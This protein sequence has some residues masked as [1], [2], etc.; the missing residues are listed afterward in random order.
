[1][2]FSDHFLL[3]RELLRFFLSCGCPKMLAHVL[4]FIMGGSTLRGIFLPYFSWFEFST[5]LLLCLEDCGL[6]VFPW[7]AIYQP[8]LS[9]C[10]CYFSVSAIPLTK[11]EAGLYFLKPELV[12]LCLFQGWVTKI[13][14]SLPPVSSHVSVFNS[15]LSPAFIFFWSLIRL[16]YSSVY[17]AWSSWCCWTHDLEQMSSYCNAEE[18]KH[19]AMILTTWLSMNLFMNEAG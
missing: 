4:C 16:T 11:A 3:R 5:F 2:I 17:W 1:M 19:D 7:A 15:L 12:F 13:T 18:A 9:V 10:L 6:P 8:L 14:T